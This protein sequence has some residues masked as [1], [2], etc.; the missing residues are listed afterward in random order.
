MEDQQQGESTPLLRAIGEVEAHLGREKQWDTKE[1]IVEFA[2]SFDNDDPLDI[3]VMEHLG[4]GVKQT[5][6]QK[7]G[8]VRLWLPKKLNAIG[9]GGRQAVLTHFSPLALNAGF[10]LRI[11]SWKPKTGQLR[12]S[13]SRGRFYQP[14]ERWDRN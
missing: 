2:T 9:Q 3:N 10:A 8:A 12:L 6:K 5:R 14:H 4:H 7:L 1:L 11:H 13:C